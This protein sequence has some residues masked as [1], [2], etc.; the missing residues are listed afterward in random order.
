MIWSWRHGPEPDRPIFR[1]YRVFASKPMPAELRIA[2]VRILESRDSY[3]DPGH[4]GA[5]FVP[6]L[7]FSFGE[8]RNCVELLICLQCHWV[9]FYKGNSV[10]YKALSPRGVAE[11]AP[12]A[13]ALFGAD[14]RPFTYESPT[15]P[16]PKSTRAE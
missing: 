15:Q 9:Y 2:L 16:A 12:I 7:G 11:L 8:G 5:C 6:R 4:G 14:A 13:E 1:D 10:R 3:V